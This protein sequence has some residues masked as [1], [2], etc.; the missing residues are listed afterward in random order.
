MSDAKAAIYCISLFNLYVTV[1][2]LGKMID[3][4]GKALG[5]LRCLYGRDDTFS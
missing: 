2:V 5:T 1:I 3:C 4:I